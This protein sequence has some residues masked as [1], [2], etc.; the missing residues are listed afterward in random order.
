MLTTN[1]FIQLVQTIRKNKAGI[2][3]TPGTKIQNAATGKTVF[4]P[5]EGEQVIRQKL[6]NLEDY[7]HAEDGVDPLVKLAVIHYQFEAIHPFIH[8]NGRTGRILN[9]LF[10]VQR[11]L[12]DLPVLYL[13]KYIIQHKRD[14]YRLL[15]TVTEKQEWESWVLYMLDAIQETA[16]FI[17]KRIIDIRDLLEETAQL[18]KRKLPARV[19]SR[20][21][22]E[23]IFRQP[24]TKV[25]FLVEE[26]I[27]KRQTA[28]E[29]LKAL[30]AI[31]ILAAQK[32]GKEVLYVN[33]R[34]YT[35]LSS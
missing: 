5:P 25:Q 9:S 6:K 14:Y 24:Y 3:K 12:L 30:E 15:R 20:D 32:K 18:A 8:G 31:E 34:L 35:L 17:R 27:A 23:L 21:L 4:T 2:Q 13:S 29:Y 19:Y 11:G 22:L 10:L 16:D 1:L 26:G 33:T 28:A 7:I